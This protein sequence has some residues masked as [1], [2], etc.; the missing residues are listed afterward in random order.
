MELGRSLKIAAVSF[1]V[2]YILFFV[3]CVLSFA[4]ANPP[5]E[6]VPALLVG[7]PVGLIAAVVAFIFS[8]VIRKS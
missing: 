2:A 4:Y 3:L 8:A 6:P 5:R 7:I 1:V